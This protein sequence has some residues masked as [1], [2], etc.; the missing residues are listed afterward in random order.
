MVDED[1]VVERINADLA[2]I[3]DW[4]FCASQKSQAMAICL[5]LPDYLDLPAV[6][7]D[8]ASFPYSVFS[9]WR[10]RYLM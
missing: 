9:P 5:K 10:I 6:I 7:I 2:A 1:L 4:S 8:D 3:S